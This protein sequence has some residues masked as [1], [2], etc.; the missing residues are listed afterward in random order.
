MKKILIG[1]TVLSIVMTSCVSMEKYAALESKNDRLNKQYSITKD[2]LSAANSENKRLMEQNK[3]LKGS[4]SNA[5]KN[6]ERLNDEL[7]QLSAEYAAAKKKYEETTA[8]YMAQLTG[9]NNDLSSTRLLLEEREKELNEKESRLEVLQKEYEERK[10]RMDD[11]TRKLEEKEQ[12]LKK[13]LEE[14][15]RAI[16]EIRQKVANALVGFENKGLKIE[17]KDGKV[18]VSMEDKLLFASGSWTVSAEGMKAITELSKILEENTD[19]NVMVEGHTDN[20]AYRGKSEVKDNWDLSV[21]RAT[22]IV[23]ALLK[24]STIEPGRITASGRGEYVPKVDNSTK[25]NRAVNR[26]TE[27]ILTPKYVELL[28]ILSK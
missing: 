5:E 10:E 19:I 8:A 2:E 1:I 18:Y 12:E 14:K 26:R 23:K 6:I 9:K 22:A 20:V 4:I 15:E 25:E 3:Q 28:D 7:Q 27:I 16:N 11:L 24:N 13:A 17:V 21:M